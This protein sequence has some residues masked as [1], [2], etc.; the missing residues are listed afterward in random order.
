MGGLKCIAKT[1]PK[2][3]GRQAEKRDGMHGEGKQSQEGE[4]WLP[5][6]G[7]QEVK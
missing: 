6:E 1:C 4:S 7:L 3:R 2:A 5:L